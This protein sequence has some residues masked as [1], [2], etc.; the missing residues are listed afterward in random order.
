MALAIV[1]APPVLPHV[2]I[3]VHLLQNPNGFDLGGSPPTSL[4]PPPPCCWEI[5]LFLIFSLGSGLSGD[6]MSSSA[7]TSSQC[8]SISLCL[9]F[10]LLDLAQ[11]VVQRGPWPLFYP[12]SV[13]FSSFA[14]FLSWFSPNWSSDEVLTPLLLPIAGW[15]PL[16]PYFLSWCFQ[17]W[18]M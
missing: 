2:Y 11:A 16:F 14:Y 10:L 7:L 4:A 5:S 15:F 3:V 18:I 9:L 8:R 6:L 12:I 13:W 1:M 17:W